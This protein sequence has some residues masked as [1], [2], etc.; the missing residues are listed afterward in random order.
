MTQT[1]YAHM[2]KKNSSIYEFKVNNTVSMSLL[3]G[4]AVLIVPKG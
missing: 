2:N 3:L 4:E 1:L